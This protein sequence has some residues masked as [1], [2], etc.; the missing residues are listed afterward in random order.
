[1]TPTCYP[2]TR[3]AKATIQVVTY[4][5]QFMA[6]TRPSSSI[7]SGRDGFWLRTSAFDPLLTVSTSQPS[8]WFGAITSVFPCHPLDFNLPRLAQKA[9]LKESYKTPNTVKVGFL[10]SISLLIETNLLRGSLQ[11]HRSPYTSPCVRFVP[12]NICLLI[13]GAAL[14]NQRLTQVQTWIHDTKMVGISDICGVH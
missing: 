10:R 9:L 7:E 2:V 6:E 13:L 14:L 1:V 8:G 4:E 5:R 12:Y 3:W 11:Q